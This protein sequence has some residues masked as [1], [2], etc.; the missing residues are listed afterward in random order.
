MT[1]LI[2]LIVVLSFIVIAL[3][4]KKKQKISKILFIVNIVQI[5][6]GILFFIMISLDMNSALHLA[7]TMY[8]YA[9][10]FFAIFYRIMLFVILPANLGFIVYYVYKKMRYAD[11]AVEPKK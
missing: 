9:K 2:F 5:F 4:Y 11:N 10:M 1:I 3:T 7:E 8:F 6:C